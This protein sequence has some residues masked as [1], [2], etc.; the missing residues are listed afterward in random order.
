M[1]I[2]PTVLAKEMMDAVKDET[3]AFPAMKKLGDAIA[4]YILQNAMIFFSWN[5]LI[6][7]VPIPIP[8]I[9]PMLPASFTN[10]KILLTPSFAPVPG[11]G[12][13]LMGLQ[14]QMGMMLATYNLKKPWMTSPG[15]VVAAPPLILITDGPSRE[16]VFNLIALQIFAWMQMVIPVTPCAGINLLTKAV[17]VAMP[18]KII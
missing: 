18:L 15:I 17:G 6:P 1:P 10:V 4:K 3:S 12:G 11:V 16:I 7:S 9:I 13:I 2:V 8:E 5:A 14:I